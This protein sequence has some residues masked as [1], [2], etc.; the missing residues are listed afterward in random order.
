MGRYAVIRDDVVENVVLW[1][2]ETKWEPPEG[3]ELVELGEES[4]GPGYT[5]VD[6]GWEAPEREDEDEDE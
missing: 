6:D 4:V 2:G 5:R 3:T 1:D